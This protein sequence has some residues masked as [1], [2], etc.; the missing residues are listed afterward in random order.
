[1]LNFHR[2]AK[3]ISINK[4]KNNNS[5]WKNQ[6]KCTVYIDFE[7][8]SNFLLKS[9]NKSNIKDNDFIFMVGIG[10]QL[11]NCDKWNFKCLYWNICDI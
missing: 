9:D 10:W 7:T 4:I 3:K 11:P 5:N 6:N 1:M 8:I 2:S